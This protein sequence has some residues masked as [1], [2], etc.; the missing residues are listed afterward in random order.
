MSGGW[1]K[2]KKKKKGEHCSIYQPTHR[3]H[4]RW[5]R[6][7]SFRFFQR[8][9]RANICKEF[10]SVNVCFL[11]FSR[12]TSRR[13]FVL[14]RSR[15]LPEPSANDT[16][17]NMMCPDHGDGE[18]RHWQ[19]TLTPV[20]FGW[21]LRLWWKWHT[22]Q[23]ILILLLPS[24]DPPL[25]SYSH[26]PTK[27]RIIRGR[28]VIEKSP[29]HV[30]VSMTHRHLTRLCSALCSLMW[31]HGY[32]ANFGKVVMMFTDFNVNAQKLISTMLSK[33]QQ[34][35]IHSWPKTSYNLALSFMVLRCS[36]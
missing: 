4:H 27:N 35:L 12:F 15:A 33:H 17:P 11:M 20:R 18:Q 28:Q 34:R 16:F 30:W 19:V 9:V 36:G 5:C 14:K 2:K 25:A 21:D 10:H 7:C 1:K 26:F 6:M 24:G 22:S 23:I 29:P 31:S 8:V 3:T 13:L 32:V